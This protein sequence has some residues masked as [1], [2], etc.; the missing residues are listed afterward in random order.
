MTAP[1]QLSIHGTCLTRVQSLVFR[2]GSNIDTTVLSTTTLTWTATTTTLLLLSPGHSGGPAKILATATTP[3]TT[4]LTFLFYA[5]PAIARTGGSVVATTSVGSGRLLTTKTGGVFAYGT[6][7]FHG[8]L[9]GLGVSV[10]DITAIASTCNDRGYWLVGKD[11]GV[12]AF[13]NATFY[14][15]LPQL[16]VTPHAPIVGIKASPGCDGYWLVSADGGVFAFGEATFYGS[17]PAD[18]VTVTDIVSMWAKDSG[19]GYYLVGSDGGVFAFGSA[20]FYGSLPNDGIKV[21]DI[22]GIASLAQTAPIL[23]RPSARPLNSVH[24]ARAALPQGYYLVGSDGGVFAFGNVPFRGSLGGSALSS[25]VV[26]IITY[27]AYSQPTAR[28]ALSPAIPSSFHIYS[29]VQ[30]NGTVT[31]YTFLPVG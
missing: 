13:G 9:P 7:H 22:V 20:T 31:N 6:S 4:G 15:S 19:E 21:N 12:F 27:S 26:G 16:G 5:T 2:T 30:A 1:T 25:P 23:G 10:S 18:G 3:V 11:G 8:S 28:P 29:L 24:P 14:G 17:L